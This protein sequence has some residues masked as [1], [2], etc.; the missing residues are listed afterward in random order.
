M[1]EEGADAEDEADMRSSQ[2]A[3]VRPVQP[4]GSRA[5]ESGAREGTAD[6]DDLDSLLQL[7]EEQ[8]RG[9]DP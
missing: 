9:V 5:G 6:A 2:R 1:W 7:W 8:D 3:A 4:A